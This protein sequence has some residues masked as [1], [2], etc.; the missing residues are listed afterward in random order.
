ML[1]WLNEILQQHFFVIAAMDNNRLSSLRQMQTLISN[2]TKNLNRLIEV[3]S[4]LDNLVCL[5]NVN[6]N[7]DVDMDGNGNVNANSTG[8]SYEP[9]L[10]YNESDSEEET[11]K[12]KSKCLTM[13]TMCRNSDSSQ[14]ERSQE[15]QF[16]TV[17]TRQKTANR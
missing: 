6:A 4:K 3:Q 11:E 5:F 10:I 8:N 1:P 12:Q 17:P 2:R 16:E 9:L 13:M 14:Q 15:D 7:V